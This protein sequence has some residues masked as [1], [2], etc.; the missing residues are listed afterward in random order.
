M[1]L[2]FGRERRLRARAEFGRVFNKGVRVGGRLFLVIALP[3]DRRQHRLGLAISR[4]IGSA[5]TRNRA[6]RL[7]RE[8]VR[9]LARP[10]GV[11]FDL[12]IVARPDI[13]GRTQAEVDGELRDRLQRLA[14]RRW[15]RRAAGSAPH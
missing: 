14:G 7:L 6:R 12:V 2:G 9:R 1:G 15:G 4:K 8:G 13:V 11:G 3:N 5:V 10:Q